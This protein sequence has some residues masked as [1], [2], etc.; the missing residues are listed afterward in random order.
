[1]ADNLTITIGADASQLRAQLAV[2]QADVR[3]YTRELSSLAN[4][5]R[6]TNDDLSFA[7][8][9]QAVS[10]LDQAAA[11][12]AKLKTELSALSGGGAGAFG[13]LLSSAERLKG[14]LIGG[15][16]ALGVEKLKQ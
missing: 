13:G 14:L 1:M 15:A 16:A 9:A 2:A 6:R 12:A 4:V 3:A 5:A 8:V 11:A 10:Q 7:K